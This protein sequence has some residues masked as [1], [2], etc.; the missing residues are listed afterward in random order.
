MSISVSE[1]EQIQSMPHL[2]G[3]EDIKQPIQADKYAAFN[4]N[5]SSSPRVVYSFLVGFFR[6]MDRLLRSGRVENK[7]SSSA[8][9]RK[10]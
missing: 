8:V 10:E 1:T 5:P 2:L 9:R 6:I 7:P 3:L 4:K